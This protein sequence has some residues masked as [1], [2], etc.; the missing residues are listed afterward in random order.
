MTQNPYICNLDSQPYPAIRQLLKSSRSYLK[1]TSKTT[2]PSQEFEVLFQS[3][4]G[5]QTE[6]HLDRPNEAATWRCIKWSQM[7]DGKIEDSFSDYNARL[8]AHPMAH[9]MAHQQ[10]ARSMF[11]AG[12]GWI[13]EP[14]SLD[15]HRIYGTSEHSGGMRGMCGKH[16]KF[17]E[18]SG[19]FRIQGEHHECQQL[20]IEMLP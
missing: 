8:M 14:T 19:C 11:Q 2:A 12:N 5:L 1:R 15:P 7:Y 13:C 4:I 17:G 16:N 3:S 6:A 10:L 18:E 9:P 20:S